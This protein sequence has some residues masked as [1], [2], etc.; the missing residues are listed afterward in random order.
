MRKSGHLVNAVQMPQRAEGSG[1]MTTGG[2]ADTEDTVGIN[3]ELFRVILDVC[4][5]KGSIGKRT[6]EK[7]FFADGI[8]QNKGIDTACQIR[9]RDRFALSVV[10]DTAVAA[11]GNDQH[12]VAGLPAFIGDIRRQCNIGIVVPQMYDLII[13]RVSFLKEKTAP[14]RRCFSLCNSY[15]YSGSQ[16]LCASMRSS[17]IATIW[18]MVSSD[19]QCGSSIAA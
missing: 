9:K 19:E 14:G 2:E 5:R 11:A 13:H 7:C 10:A 18:S 6:R 8:L 17:H 12:R 4:H 1:Q 15:L 3:V 16:P